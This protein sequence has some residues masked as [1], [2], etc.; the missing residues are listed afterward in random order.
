MSSGGQGRRRVRT[1]AI[2]LD[3]ITELVL[4]GHGVPV[5]ARSARLIEL[6]GWAAHRSRRVLTRTAIKNQLLS[7]LDWSAPCFP[8]G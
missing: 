2:D 4:A 8:D 6:T 5:T 1:D 3:A 7:Q